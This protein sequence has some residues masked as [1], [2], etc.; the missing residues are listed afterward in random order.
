M[1][2]LPTTGGSLLLSLV[3][4]AGVL[5]NPITAMGSETS[6][7]WDSFS[8]SSGCGEPFTGT[9]FVSKQ[10]ILAE[11]EPILGPFGTYFGRSIADVR[12][13]LVTWVVPGSGGRT[14]KVHQAMAPALNQV[15][16]TLAAEASNGR[17][18]QVTSVAGFVARTIRGSYQLS[19]H[20]LGLSIDINP[21]QN[22]YRA[23][24]RLITN[25][26][27][28]F[29]DAWRS[30]GFCWGGDWE[31]AKDP[32]HFSWI[33]PGA[34]GS[35]GPGISPRAPR[36]SVAPFGGP[37][38]SHAT[39]FGP[40]MSRYSFSIV[41]G[42]GNGAPD[43]V[44]LRSHPD[45]AVI[46]IA[47]GIGGYG[48]SSIARWFVPDSTVQGA[49]HIVFGDVDGD[50]G[51]DLIALLPLDGSL[52]AFVATRRAEFQTTTVRF[53]GLK[54]DAVSVTAADFDGDRLA[55]L[56]EATS[57]GRL[58]VWR[59]PSWSELISD[60]PLPAGVPVRIVAAD[61]DGGDTPELFALYPA[62]G[63]SSVEVM[64][65]NGAW[66]ADESIALSG[67]PGSIAAI[68]AG[69]YDGDGRADLQ[70]LDVSGTLAVY[71]GNTPTGIPSSRWFLHPDWDGE[72]HDLPLSFVGT[73]YDD[74]DSM[75]QPNIEAI[76]AAA[77]T[78]GCNPPFGDLFCPK[79]PV[80]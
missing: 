52:N 43:V 80:T 46:D 16:A 5:A 8:E 74:D 33:G 60:E 51:Q 14:V 29:V 79:D 2:L 72:K 12:S 21:A 48:G 76:A 6:T 69:D 17:V 11:S 77:I 7:R 65:F 27:G 24:N 20:G 4:V 67:S 40:V 53:T 68:G 54:T 41:D 36:T 18:Y 62:Q 59:G 47:R 28:W 55:D 39:P 75:F 34:E 9:P 44:G 58:K 30:A 38:A 23:D 25:M 63:G 26:P 19:R 45:G 22:P 78:N 42:T 71:L 50:S 64:T 10:G 31:D 35:P 32:M 13:S 57:D 49:Q 56:W 66:T 61:R 15:A 70:V 3:L 73:F 37:S 1:R